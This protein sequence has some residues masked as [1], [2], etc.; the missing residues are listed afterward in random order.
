MFRCFMLPSH[1]VTTYKSWNSLVEVYKLNFQIAVTQS[2]LISA[3]EN[4]DVNV[5]KNAL[6]RF[7]KTIDTVNRRVYSKAT[8]CAH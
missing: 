4:T 7:A 5:I 6:V 1:L 3:L 8:K 2:I